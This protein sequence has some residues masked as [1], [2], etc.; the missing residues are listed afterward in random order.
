ME[1]R[2]DSVVM[3]AT[4]FGA[5]AVSSHLATANTA[6]AGNLATTTYPR[7]AANP[8]PA[9]APRESVT[10]KGLGKHVSVA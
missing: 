4:G 1:N 5:G 6:L 7:S 2:L 3:L 8:Q 10:L 9:A